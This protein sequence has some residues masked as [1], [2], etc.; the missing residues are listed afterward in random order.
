M[1]RRELR[2][3]DP[4]TWPASARALL[5]GRQGAM[6]PTEARA[7]LGRFVRERGRV[8]FAEFMERA[9]YD[10]EVGYYRD[11][12]ER[13]GPRG[14]YVTSPEMHPAF[15]ALLARWLADRWRTLGEPDP[16][17]VVEVGPG[18]GAAAAQILA[19]LP[20]AI[21][22]AVRYTLV[23][24]GRT[25]ARRQAE[26]LAEFGTHC[27]WVK[28]LEEGAPVVGVV[29][30]NELLDAL[31][32]HRVRRD[33]D[34]LIELW[35]TYDARSSQ[36]QEVAGPLSTP[37]LEEYFAA[38]GL[39]PIEGVPVEVN[40][41]AMDWLRRAARALERGWLLLFDYGSTAER[42]YG[43]PGRAGTL[44]A[45]HRHT[46]E[47][48][49]YARIGAQDLTADVDFTTLLRVAGEEGLRV[50]SFTDQRP[51]LA[52]LGIRE[53]LRR[54]PAPGEPGHWCLAQLIDPEG[55]GRIRVL[56]LRRGLLHGICDP[57]ETR[58]Q[59][60][61]DEGE[62]RPPAREVQDEGTTAISLDG[63]HRLLDQGREGA[64][65]GRLEERQNALAGAIAQVDHRPALILQEVDGD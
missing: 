8:P 3:D 5:R 41:Q 47:P 12:A 49:P 25:A 9:L 29:W 28:D 19:A 1:S 16:F 4:E 46:L 14:D 40:L 35:V 64:G 45:Y 21:G 34:R 24:P 13:I 57:L 33:G 37:R 7:R 36:F 39:L 61:A 20:R 31:P 63:R 23:E 42:L 60:R 55:L 27:R 52:S 2:L 30:A 22:T 38:L 18:T 17:E 48:D 10:P 51:F 26:R 44:R 62:A 65:G 43:E 11:P 58:L 6:V 56:T 59:E 32:V 54:P 15:G 53:F 50:E